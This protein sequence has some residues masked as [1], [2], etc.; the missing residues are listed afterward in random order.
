[1]AEAQYAFCDDAEDLPGAGECVLL[2]AHGDRA[3]S[4]SANGYNPH[5]SDTARELLQKAAPIFAAALS[6]P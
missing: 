1:M 4:I 3:T 5:H 6:K 2:L